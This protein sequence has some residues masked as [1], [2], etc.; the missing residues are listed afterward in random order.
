[1]KSLMSKYTTVCKESTVTS[2]SCYILFSNRTGRD[3][4]TMAIEGKRVSLANYCIFFSVFR[5]RIWIHRIHMFLGLPDPDPLV[6]G[7]DPDLDP[8]I[9]LLSSSKNSKKNLILT[10]LWLLLDF[11]FFL[12]ASWR[13]FTK[14]AGSGSESGSISQRHGSTDPDPY[15]NFMGPER[16]SWIRFFI[17]IRYNLFF[18]SYSLSSQFLNTYGTCG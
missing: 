6:R 18:L 7:V 12:L 11:F 8:Y 9:I 16:G 15:Q 13:S 2:N 5:I 14:I 1:M 10:V 17:L 3:P 4:C